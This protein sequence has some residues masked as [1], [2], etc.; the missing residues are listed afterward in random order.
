M[1]G[2]PLAKVNAV[3][4]SGLQANAV[5]IALSTRGLFSRA[6]EIPVWRGC[7]GRTVT[8]RRR[9][10]SSR[11]HREARRPKDGWVRLAAH[12]SSGFKSRLEDLCKGSTSCRRRQSRCREAADEGSYPTTSLQEHKRNSAGRTG[13]PPQH[14][15]SP[16]QESASWLARD[17]G[18]RNVRDR[19]RPR[20]TRQGPIP[21]GKTEE[22]QR[23]IVALTPGESR[24]EPRGRSRVRQ[25]RDQCASDRQ[26]Q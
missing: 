10:A 24:E 3:R 20:E 6:Y 12:V 21:L 1:P 11:T 5:Q 4:S 15:R 9:Q 22:S 2:G 14:W 26:T 25:M 18:N 23:L 13:E 8:A 16:A 7:V 17:G 19:G